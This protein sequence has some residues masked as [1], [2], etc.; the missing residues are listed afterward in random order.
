M[1]KDSIHNVRIVD[2]KVLIT[3]AELTHKLPLPHVLRGPIETHRS[4]GKG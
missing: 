2:E 3:P 1:N 4:D